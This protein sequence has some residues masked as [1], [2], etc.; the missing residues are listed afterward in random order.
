MKKTFL[1]L[2]LALFCSHFSVARAD[3]SAESSS[4]TN[5]QPEA[6]EPAAPAEAAQAAAQTEA[7]K[8]AA[9]AEAAKPAAPKPAAGFP[10]LPPWGPRL[11]KVTSWLTLGADL[12][13]REEY[14]LNALT[15]NGTAVNHEYNYLRYRWRLGGSVQPVKGLE[16]NFRVI[17][18]TR[19]YAK[20]ESIE[21]YHPDEILFDNFNVTLRNPGGT[22]ITIVA[23]RQDIVFGNGWLI[24]D[25]T[26]GDGSR[27]IFFDA[28]R[29]TYE[30]KSKKTTFDFIGIGNGSLSD[31]KLPV[32]HPASSAYAKFPKADIEQNENG[33]I[34][35]LTN[36]SINKT[37]IDGYFIYKHDSKVQPN[38]N[39]GDLYVFGARI[40]RDLS[41]HLRYR[42][43][44]APERG[45]K[46][47][48]DLRAFGLNQRLTYLWKN[49]TNQ[50]VYVGHEYLS[51]DD[52]ATT[53]VNEGFDPVWG[54]W[55]QWSELMLYNQA[56]ETR[57]G[58]W[59]NFHRLDFGWGCSLSK[60][61]DLSAD[62]MP[63]FAPNNPIF[64]KKPGYSESGRFRGHY[65]QG[66]LR[67]RFNDHINGHLWAEFFLPRDYYTV[68][69]SDAA[70][71]L[72]AEVIFRW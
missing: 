37:Q 69:K 40:E 16:F 56:A 10:G 55:P 12:R 15:L 4:A 13:I 70:C 31:Q 8:P 9:P 51:G 48:R 49:K 25:G 20:P 6:A 3:D 32:I 45:N 68:A 19:S 33:A 11:N 44:V 2:I 50:R 17:S 22:P 59:T 60:K 21:G 23:G 64:G 63:L 5:A 65:G 1:F 43:E 30:L 36:K 35:Y 46:N 34:F 57:V 61:L 53:G 54:R 26:P 38:G 67:Y 58:E 24:M 7:T 52:P 62:Y 41:N 47:G 71:F 39:N 28:I 18:E 42:F 72:R 29:L 27:S 66:T 14:H